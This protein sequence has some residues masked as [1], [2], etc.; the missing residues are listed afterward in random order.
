MYL[1]D[2]QRA[3][4]EGDTGRHEVERMHSREKAVS[5]SWREFVYY[6]ERNPM[7]KELSKKAS[8]K[9]EEFLGTGYVER[10]CYVKGY[11]IAK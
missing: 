2:N 10:I 5:T 1:S 11:T 9:A 7:A 6:E 8:N 3:Q 4:R